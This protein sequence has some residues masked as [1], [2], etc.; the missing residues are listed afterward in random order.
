ME[1]LRQT[2]SKLQEKIKKLAI[3]DEAM[4]DVIGCNSKNLEALKNY[5]VEIYGR[6]G[7]IENELKHKNVVKDDLIYEKV[8]RVKREMENLDDRIDSIEDKLVEDMEN[9]ENR[10]DAGISIS[11]DKQTEESK[12]LKELIVENARKLNQ[13]EENLLKQKE[14][15]KK[16]TP[17]YKCDECGLSFRKKTERRDH[18]LKYHPKHIDCDLCE[19]SFTES[20]RYETHLESHS[21]QKDFRCETCG[22]EFFMEWRLS[23]HMNI[24]ENPNIKSCHY[25]NNSNS[26]PFENV[27]CKFKHEKSENCSKPA[28]CKIK[29]CPKQHI[30]T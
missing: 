21:K 18:I 4:R 14:L 22:K 23:Q 15:L 7:T 27:G 2:V 12:K 16:T 28:S 19:L 3:S 13:V 25:Y 10:I 20:W 11:V 1:E 17:E 29:L 26:C 6:V 30:V 24:H 9:T 8:E 5:T